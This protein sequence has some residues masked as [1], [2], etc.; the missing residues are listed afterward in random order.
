MNGNINQQSLLGVC[1]NTCVYDEAGLTAM[2]I[3]MHLHNEHTCRHIYTFM[4]VHT[5]LHA[6]M[7]AC[8]YANTQ[9]LT[10]SHLHLYI[11]IMVAIRV[12]GQFMLF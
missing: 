11:S 12:R 3:G 10:L 4:R 8:T 7:H 1:S 5:E 2:Y 9:T 6:R